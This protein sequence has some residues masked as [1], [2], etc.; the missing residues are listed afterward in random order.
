MPYIRVAL[1][2]GLE[3]MGFP[4]V[5]GLPEVLWPDPW[6]QVSDSGALLAASMALAAVGYDCI[7]SVSDVEFADALSRV[8][9]HVPAGGEARWALERVVYER[10]G[11]PHDDYR[12]LHE[13]VPVL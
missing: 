5:L 10:G 11:T 13:V 8:P 12:T 4:G 3:S 9:G 2:I 6:V 1:N 7:E